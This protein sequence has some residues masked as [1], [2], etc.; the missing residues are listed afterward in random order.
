M[1]TL[2]KIIVKDFRNI[3]SAELKFSPKI[4]CISG[5]NGEGK[6]NLIDAIYYLSMT[7]SAFQPNDRQNF[8]F[9]GSG[10]FS[11][12]GLYSMP[13][14]MVSKFSIQVSSS[15][16]K[17]VRRDSKVC[18]RISDHIGLLPVVLVSPSDTM[19]V[20]ESGEYRRR[21]VN[22]VLSQ[23]D[24]KYLSDIQ[25]YNRLLAQRNKLLKDMSP[26]LALLGVLA[27]KMSQLAGG[28]YQARAK[29][30][31]GLVPLASEFYRMISGGRES[32][33]IH[34][35]SDLEKAPL[36]DILESVRD[37]DLAVGFTTAGI[38]RDDFIFSLDGHPIR[39]AGSQGQQKSFLVALKFAQYELMRSSYGFGPILLLD[40]VFDKL[41]MDRVSNLISMVAGNG[42]GQIFIT[43]SNKVRL[44]SIVD[45][46]A[47]DRMYLETHG[48]V[49]TPQNL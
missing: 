9:G 36:S 3:E 34:Y 37:R 30:I 22:G 1:A 21:F 15:G 45:R 10:Q 47:E 12:T 39:S 26:D 31:E 46:V 48:G 6:T 16:E 2:D 29:F 19:L 43:D 17:K 44:Q 25:Q 18:Q 13:D 23:M 27:S 42:F 24:S 41:D 7:K 8:R 32:I 33:G 5:N 11:I 4:N 28:L 38:Q 35:S 40:D 20:S 49:F 14:G